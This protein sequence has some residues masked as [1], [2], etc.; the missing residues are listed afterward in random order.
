MNTSEL[1]LKSNNSYEY[2]NWKCVCENQWLP[3][4][5]VSGQVASR[6]HQHKDASE[7][8]AQ[9]SVSPATRWEDESRCVRGTFSSLQLTLGPGAR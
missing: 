4:A 6:E 3:E 1:R 9:Q 7:Q 8:F 5:V 2:A